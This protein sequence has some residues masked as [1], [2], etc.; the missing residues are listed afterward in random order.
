MQ[1]GTKSW[2]SCIMFHPPI[3]PWFQN[4]LC[5]FAC[6][7]S[8]V[9]T[10]FQLLG[11]SP[12]L[13]RTCQSFLK[14]NVGNLNSGPGSDRA[15]RPR[16]GMLCAVR[17]DLLWRRRDPLPEIH[18]DLAW[19]GWFGPCKVYRARVPF[20]LGQRRTPEKGSFNVNFQRVPILFLSRSLVATW[21]CLCGLVPFLE[22]FVAKGRLSGHPVMTFSFPCK[23]PLLK[24]QLPRCPFIL[25]ARWVMAIVTNPMS[26]QSPLCSP[27]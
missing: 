6:V 17:A 20:L 21:V 3:L 2:T 5:L 24:Q 7:S 4:H 26:L 1:D 15:C 23:V 10:I 14:R 16:P 8:A 19:G 25:T 22:L 18:L 12:Q 9:L 11:H 27:H 13:R